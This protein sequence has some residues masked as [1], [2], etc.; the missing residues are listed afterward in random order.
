MPGSAG[1][2]RCDGV[3]VDT[4]GT[5]GAAQKG[6]AGREPC[7]A[8]ALE[9]A[10]VPQPCSALGVASSAGGVAPEGAASLQS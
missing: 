9:A 4:R 6:L 8:S 10:V 1:V 5:T 2:A 7:R 3:G